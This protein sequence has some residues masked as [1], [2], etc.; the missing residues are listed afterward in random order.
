MKFCCRKGDVNVNLNSMPLITENRKLRAFIISTLKLFQI[1]GLLLILI[2]LSGCSIVGSNKP[3]ALQITSKPEA[4]VFL[5][6]K[7]IGKTPFFSDGLKEGTYII[8][9][10]ASEASYV[11]K[12][13]LHSSTLTVVNRDLNDNLF[14]QSGEVLW[15][16]SGK[17]DV[18]FATSPQNAE[19]TLDGVYKGRS[20][21]Y[22][23]DLPN[24]EHKVQVSKA[25]YQNREFAIKTSSDYKLISNVTL[26]S[27]DAKNPAVSKKEDAVATVEILANPQGFLRVR[28][29]PALD[30][31]EVGRVNP[32]EAFE[33]I[34]ETED[35]VKISFEGK[36]GWVSSQYTK[37]I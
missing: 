26:A 29:E 13:S 12:I 11:D 10:S 16:E 8:K 5:D 17:N 24:G 22:I 7:H 2:V 36:L 4:S 28:K 20:P 9:I 21:I 34:Q 25:G 19:I 32:G 6:G 27:Q 1:S 14:A 31:P 23:S 15:L 37:K 33:I 35:W 18:F 3:A 30:S